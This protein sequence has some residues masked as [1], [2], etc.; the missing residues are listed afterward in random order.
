M[1]ERRKSRALPFVNSK[2]TLIELLVVIAIIAILASMLLPALNKA[3]TK[4][5]DTVCLNNQKQIY[6]GMMGY[7]NDYRGFC[8]DPS[9]ASYPNGATNP[10]QWNELLADGGY[11]GMKKPKWNWSYDS[12]G[13]GVFLCPSYLIGTPS[14]TNVR[15]QCYGMSPLINPANNPLKTTMLSRLKQDK[16]FFADGYY[17]IFATPS[18]AT[19][20][21]TDSISGVF[22]RHKDGGSNST[23]IG[24]AVLY[25]KTWCLIPWT[26]LTSA[27]PWRY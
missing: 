19:V 17:P 7:T 13:K 4:A 10:W 20:P 12:T 25:N 1:K 2:F 22:G 16:I 18:P 21:W 27:S 14:P 23:L 8:P 6:A 11:V 24:G 15:N 5:R 9:T 26:P 3:R